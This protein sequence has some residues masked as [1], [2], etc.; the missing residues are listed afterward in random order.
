M[1][2]KASGVCVCVCACMCVCVCARARVRVR[3]C[4]RVCV[5]AACVA[6]VFVCAR[7]AT[8][9]H[10]VRAPPVQGG[11]GRLGICVGRL[12][13]Q[14]PRAPARRLQSRLLRARAWWLCAARHSRGGPRPLETRPQPELLERAASKGFSDFVV[15]R[16][17]SLRN[18]T[19]M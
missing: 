10:A 12:P 13:W 17:P 11:A 16:F 18:V 3:V 14:L 7:H 2:S 15:S 5:C 9:L 1:F 8:P 4:A 6:C 19:V